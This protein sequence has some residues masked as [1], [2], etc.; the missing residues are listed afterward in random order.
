[1]SMEN[2]YI[3]SLH[4]MDAQASCLLGNFDADDCYVIDGKVLED[5]KACNKLI[6][7]Y[8]SDLIT[9]HAIVAG[10]KINFLVYIQEGEEGKKRAGLFVKEVSKLNLIDKELQT[11]VD[12]IVLDDNGEF[13]DIV[14]KEFHLFTPDESTGIDMDNLTLIE[15]MKRIN[16]VK[17]KYDALIPYMVDL[18]R[19]Y[20]M[21]ML[22]LLKSSGHY[23]E[24]LVA[25]FRKLVLEKKLNKLDPKYWRELKLLLDKTILRNID[26]FDKATIEKIEAIQSLYMSKSKDVKIQDNTAQK[27]AKKAA[28][29]KKKKDDKKKKE[30]EKDKK[31]NKSSSKT[32]DKTAD[33]P[34]ARELGAT[35]QG[36]QSPKYSKKKERQGEVFGV[37][38]MERVTNSEIGRADRFNESQLNREDNNVNSNGGN[39]T[40][41]GRTESFLQKKKDDDERTQ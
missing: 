35:T 17:G 19:E 3:E 40:R 16:S 38:R 21:K 8:K 29:P 32:E 6:T 18:D 36:S 31:S 2:K 7:E 28:E 20:V 24:M 26:V 13:L 4:N 27:P 5:L 33:P 34:K 37:K 1:M 10:V 30:E 12:S 39:N 15:L 41:D 23:G 11:Y 14:K 9:A 25:E 22:L